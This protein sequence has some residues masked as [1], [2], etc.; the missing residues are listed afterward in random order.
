[1]AD[2]SATATSVAV[3]DPALCVIDRTCN[4]DDTVAQGEMV[5]IS[6]ATTS[7]RKLKR[8]DANDTAAKAAAH[9]MALVAGSAGQ[10]AVILRFGEVNPG[11][12]G[13]IGDI[14]CLSTNLGKLCDVAGIGTG[15]FTTV[16]GVINT[17]SRLY[18]D[19]LTPAMRSA[20][21]TP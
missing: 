4:F 3:I 17:A 20:T 1:M 14:V 19:C 21:V 2:Y 9:G 5:Y 12:A 7:P 18:V 16:V 15:K 11:F 10:P 13:V 8:T 6:D